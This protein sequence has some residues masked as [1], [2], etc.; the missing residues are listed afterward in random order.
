MRSGEYSCLFKVGDRVRK[1]VSL[2]ILNILDITVDFSSA[3]LSKIWQA[4]EINFK[5][6]PHA[7]CVRIYL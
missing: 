7:Q 1:I 6:G 3:V 4:R 2:V 5:M